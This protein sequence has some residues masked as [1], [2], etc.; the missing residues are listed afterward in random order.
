MPDSLRS[1]KVHTILSA[2]KTSGD[3]F[4]AIRGIDPKKK[5]RGFITI[6]TYRTTKTKILFCCFNAKN[7]FGP[8]PWDV[9]TALSV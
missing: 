7:D 6:N 9:R 8:F 4:I 2:I 1:A 5:P 3:F